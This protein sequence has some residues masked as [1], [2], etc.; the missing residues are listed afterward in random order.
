ML[1]TSVHVIVLRLFQTGIFFGWKGI[2]IMLTSK[3]KLYVS[4]LRLFQTGISF[5]WKGRSIMLRSKYK[6]IRDINPST[7]PP[8]TLNALPDNVVFAFDLKPKSIKM[9]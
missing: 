3:Y 2:S 4:G 1:Y 6:L 7:K 5:G 9:I 8:G